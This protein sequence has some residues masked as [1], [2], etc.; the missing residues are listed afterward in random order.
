MGLLD[1]LKKNAFRHQKTLPGNMLQLKIRTSNMIMMS[2][3]IK[4]S[5][6]EK[7]HVTRSEDGRETICILGYAG[8]RSPSSS[9]FCLILQ[10]QMH[11]PSGPVSPFD[12]ALFLCSLWYITMIELLRRF[13]KVQFL[14]FLL[15]SCMQCLLSSS[16]PSSRL[17]SVTLTNN[18]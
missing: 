7:K 11:P 16:S 6:A 10:K 4:V 2:L 12:L 14:R 5:H 3:D 18:K 13:Q 15:V 9:S 1:M 8:S 17:T